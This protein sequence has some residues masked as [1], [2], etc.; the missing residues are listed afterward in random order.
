M[1]R[2]RSRNRN[3]RRKRNGQ[4]QQNNEKGKNRNRKILEKQLSNWMKE[5]SVLAKTVT[6][7]ENGRIKKSKIFKRI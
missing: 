7:S 6:D 1:E 3:E 2:Y 4:V 5:I